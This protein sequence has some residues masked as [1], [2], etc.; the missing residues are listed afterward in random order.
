MVVSEIEILVRFFTKLRRAVLVRQS[1]KIGRTDG[2][3]AA[4]YIAYF[5]AN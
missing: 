1:D 3:L 4:M 2:Y 5:I